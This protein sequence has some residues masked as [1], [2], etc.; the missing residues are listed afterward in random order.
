MPRSYLVVV[1]LFLLILPVC[2]QNRPPFGTTTVKELTIRVTYERGE[3][4]EMGIRV[5]LLTGSGTP[6][7]D[8]YTDDHG[9]VRF[10][11]EPGPYR[12]RITGMNIEEATSDRS[13]LVEPRESAHMEYFTVRKKPSE[14]ETSSTQTHVSA[15]MLQ[16]PNKARS[17]CE[18]GLKALAKKD[19]E[20]ARKHLG[21]A[22]E[23]YPKYAEAFNGLGVLAMN[24]GEPAVGK[25]QFEKAIEVDPEHPAAFVNLSKIMMQQKD[26]TGGEQMLTKA[27]SLDPLNSEAI[28]LLAFFQLQLGK[29]EAAIAS[30]ERAHQM[31]HAGFA[32]VH[33]IAGNAY[34][35]RHQIPGA[36][37]EYKLF[38]EESPPGSSVAQRVKAALEGL[39][40]RSR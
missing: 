7:N 29:F 23:I 36:I 34:E 26:F 21:R 24:T 1:S 19:Y 31:P 25:H 22:T 38:L 14:A 30:A 2:G 39:E 37:R 27:V 17:E 4:V 33:F 5:Q 11:V 20:K 12:V 13:F 40:A 10:M 9:T 32:M 16:I 35:Q 18:K 28:S 8:S 15:A 6:F 3:P